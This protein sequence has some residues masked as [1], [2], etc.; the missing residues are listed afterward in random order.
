MNTPPREIQNKDRFTLLAIIAVFLLPFVLAWM[1]VAGQFEW[2]PANTINH[3]ILLQPPLQLQSFGVKNTEGESLKLNATPRDWFLVVLHTHACVELCQSL[4]QTGERIRIAVGRN[5]NS[6]TVTSLGP[7]DEAPLRQ[8][9]SW[10]FPANGKLIET[11]RLTIGD[12]QLNTALL[13]VDYAGRIVL[14]YPS[15]EDGNGALK[16]LERLLRSTAR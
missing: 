1:F 16:D 8:G 7:D 12:S 3:G 14:V 6:V 13:I 9:Q 15:S 5:M 2:R 11:L 10:L 4:Y